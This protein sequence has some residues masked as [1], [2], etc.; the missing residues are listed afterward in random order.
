[1]EP[2]TAVPSQLAAEARRRG[3]SGLDDRASVA[4]TLE[5]L[6]SHRWAT[7]DR[8]PALYWGLGPATPLTL[9]VQALTGSDASRDRN[10]LVSAVQR[11]EM[12][13]PEWLVS[14]LCPPQDIA[15]TE[16]AAHGR[17]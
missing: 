3:A 8:Q 17:R 4:Q 12:E 11:I 7:Y 9:A 16:G 5:R 1:M 2:E 13:P 14:R 6:R 15:P 10:A